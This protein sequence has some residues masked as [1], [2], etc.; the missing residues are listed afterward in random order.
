[1][2]NATK[3]LTHSE[4]LQIMLD[5]MEENSTLAT[6]SFAGPEGKKL[7]RKKWDELT[8]LLNGAGFGERSREKWQKTWTDLKSK[9]RSRAAQLK[10]QSNKTGGGEKESKELT[11]IEERILALIGPSSF[12]GTNTPERGLSTTSIMPIGTSSI[13]KEKSTAMKRKYVEESD[14]TYVVD[15]DE[16]TTPKRPRKEDIRLAIYEKTLSSLETIENTLR[17]GLDKVAQGF[18]VLA[19]AINKLNK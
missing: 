15:T 16:V 17:V 4:H 1:M 13:V 5:F 8:L 14:H 6:G 18:Q 11:V 19:Q 3:F 12:E 7:Q 10:L 9:S 2:E